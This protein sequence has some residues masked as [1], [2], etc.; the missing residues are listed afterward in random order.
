M[1]VSNAGMSVRKDGLW[2]GGTPAG[3]CGGLVYGFL[4][5]LLFSSNHSEVFPVCLPDVPLLFQ[6]Q[7][8]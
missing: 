4:W 5:K 7:V 2:A 1:Q 6:S 8:L 3:A